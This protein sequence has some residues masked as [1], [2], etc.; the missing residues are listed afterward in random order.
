MQIIPLKEGNY[1]VD[2]N[3]RF[4]L[5][6]AENQS[7]LKGLNVGVQPF[8]IITDNDFILL[9]TGLGGLVN[10]IPLIHL[11]LAKEHIKPEQITKVLISHLHK[12]HVLGIGHFFENRFIPNFPNAKIYM[13]TRE[14]DYVKEQKGNTSYLFEH[15]EEIIKLPNIEWMTDDKGQ[16]TPEI[17]YEVVG[18]HTPFHQVFLIKENEQIAFYGGDNLPQTGYLKYHF[19]YKNDFDGKKAMNWREQWKILAE[20]EHWHI[21][22][23]HD[24][25][26]AV[27][28]L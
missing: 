22:L 3:K 1:S 11:L 27:V 15:L 16:I 25:E 5:I 8:L 10:E 4:T 14:W 26:N 23:Y 18:G 2:K 17:Y 7:V 9:D 20:K 24:V 12:D 19:A 13:Q 6:T 28:Q 21:L